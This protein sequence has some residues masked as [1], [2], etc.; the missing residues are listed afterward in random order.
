MKEK[1]HEGNQVNQQNNEVC[2]EWVNE[3]WPSYYIDPLYC[4]IICIYVNKTQID[5]KNMSVT[6]PLI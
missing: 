4:A 2:D 5:I 1:Y 6:E 3:I